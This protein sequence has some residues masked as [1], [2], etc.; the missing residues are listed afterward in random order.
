MIWCRDCS[1]LY[2]ILLTNLPKSY[3]K[4]SVRVSADELDWSDRSI[5]FHA[6]AEDWWRE[7]PSDVNVHVGRV[8]TSMWLSGVMSYG[9][10][11]IRYKLFKVSVDLDY[12]RSLGD[13]TYD[14]GDGWMD[15][16]TA[17]LNAYEY[18]GS[19]SLYIPKS[20]LKYISSREIK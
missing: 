5:W 14:I 20:K 16:S 13:L 19:V 4:E 18:P 12:V 6:G 17:Y 2:D 10:S 8:E 1:K 11:A 15:Q 3:T 9:S 7:C